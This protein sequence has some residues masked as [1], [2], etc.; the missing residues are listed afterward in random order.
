VLLKK[1]TQ[2]PGP[3]REELAIFFLQFWERMGRARALSLLKS[4]TCL[5]LQYLAVALVFL[6]KNVGSI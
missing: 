3:G 6:V 2:S 1:E 4:S 5:H